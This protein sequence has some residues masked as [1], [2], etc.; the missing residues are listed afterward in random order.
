MSDDM[1]AEAAK[2]YDV[3]PTIRM[4][5]PSIR[6]A[7]PRQ[8]PRSWNW[9]AYGRVLLP[10]AAVCGFIHAWIVPGHAVRVACRSCSGSDTPTKHAG[11]R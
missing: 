3:N 8:T 2:Y 9:A 5:S 7:S 1:R 11:T 4:I 6:H 10:L